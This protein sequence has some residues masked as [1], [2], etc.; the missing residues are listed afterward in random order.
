MI[1]PFGVIIIVIMCYV[2]MVSVVP[3][4]EKI[5]DYFKK[6]KEEFNDEICKDD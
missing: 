6:K 4:I 1:I 3:T 2:F 5:F